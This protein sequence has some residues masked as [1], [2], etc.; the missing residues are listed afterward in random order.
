M[1]AHGQYSSTVSRITLPNVI[2]RRKVFAAR[3]GLLPALQTLRQI[4][5]LALW[6]DTSSPG[7]SSFIDVLL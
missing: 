3:A 4:A 2:T 6:R 7:N 5:F 1:R